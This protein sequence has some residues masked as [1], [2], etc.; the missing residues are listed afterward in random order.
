MLRDNRQQPHKKPSSIDNS[1]TARI[2]L[3]T[4]TLELWHIRILQSNNP[5]SSIVHVIDQPL[6]RNCN[7]IPTSQRTCIAPIL[8]TQHKMSGADALISLDA[9]VHQKNHEIMQQQSILFTSILRT[10]IP[11]IYHTVNLAI[12]IIVNTYGLRPSVWNTKDR[13]DFTD[14]H[15]HA[16]LPVYWRANA[17]RGNR[18]KYA[19]FGECGILHSVEEWVCDSF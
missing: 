11:A 12:G 15:A 7:Q 13:P 16:L 8:P 9:G 2:T 14:V 5:I 18:N 1:I 19:Y 4:T 10:D 3:C 6:L 17:D